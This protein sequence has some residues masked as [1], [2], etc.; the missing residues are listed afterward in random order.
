MEWSDKLFV[1]DCLLSWLVHISKIIVVTVLT[2]GVSLCT[3]CLS[4]VLYLSVSLLSL[5]R[6]ASIP[7]LF[8][9]CQLFLKSY[10]MY[11]KTT[12]LLLYLL[13]RLHK[14]FI[15]HKLPF[16]WFLFSNKQR[17]LNCIYLAYRVQENPMLIKYFDMVVVQAWSVVSVCL[18]TMAFA[19]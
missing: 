1:W 17:A 2:E 7:F 14:G 8:H 10:C 3:R 19:W 6:F 15:W 4:V 13:F 9:L 11:S 18:C 12:S 5:I 16:I